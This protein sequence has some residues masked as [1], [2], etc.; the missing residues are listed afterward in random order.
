MSSLQDPVGIT[1]GAA[2][3]LSDNLYL[4]SVG[5]AP[6]ESPK[7]ISDHVSLLF[8]GILDKIAPR[9][10]KWCIM[11]IAAHTS[12]IGAGIISGNEILNARA[13]DGLVVVWY[14]Y[15]IVFWPFVWMMCHLC[16][17]ELSL[18]FGILQKIESA[19]IYQISAPGPNIVIRS[20]RVWWTQYQLKG[21]W[22]GLA[23]RVDVY[24]Q[25][26]L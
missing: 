1:L 12:F 10:N 19:V 14:Y 3:K 22:G 23:L 11:M 6:R 18:C 7:N 21:V 15:L 13:S 9:E 20:Y 24:F 17:S 25:I 16:I 5:L 4:L 2:R 8:Y 26:K